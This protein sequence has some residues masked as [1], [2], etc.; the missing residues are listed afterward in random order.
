MFLG[1]C[2]LAGVVVGRL[3]RGAV[4]ANTSLDS[5]DGSSYGYG[6][7]YSGSPATYATTAP[8]TG[9]STGYDTG[10]SGAGSYGGDTTTG[11]SIGVTPRAPCPRRAEPTRATS[12]C[13][14]PTVDRMI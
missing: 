10:Y 14:L 6:G 1:L 8:D 13:S 2:A 4:A 3:G 7:S 5:K 12:A 9:Y 11:P